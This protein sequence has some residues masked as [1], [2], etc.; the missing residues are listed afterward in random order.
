MKKKIWSKLLSCLVAVA[1]IFAMGAN[2]MAEPVD[3]GSGTEVTEQQEDKETDNKQDDKKPEDQEKNEDPPAQQDD[4]ESGDKTVA[5]ASAE[6]PAAEVAPKSEEPEAAPVPEEGGDTPD[7]SIYYTFTLR[8][9]NWNAADIV[10]STNDPDCVASEPHERNNKFYY[11]DGH[12]SFYLSD[13]CPFTAP[14][15]YEFDGWDIANGL[16]GTIIF[17]IQEDMVAT[18]QWAKINT[19]NSKAGDNIIWKF[20]MNTGTLTLTGTGAMYDYNKYETP[21]YS[22]IDDIERIVVSE[23]ITVIG[24]YAFCDCWYMYSITLP[25]SL[26]TIKNHAFENCASL[27]KIVIPAGVTAIGVSSDPEDEFSDAFRGCRYLY[28]VYLDANPANLTWNE[29][30]NDF[31]LKDPQTVCHVRSEYLSGYNGNSFSEVN[32]KFEGDLC[33]PSMSWSFNADNGELMLSGSGEM[34]DY[35]DAAS[36]PW[37]S[38]KTSI[39]SLS[40]DNSGDITI[41]NDA[42]NGCVNLSGADLDDSGITSIGTSSFEGCTSFKD[43]TFPSSLTSIGSRAFYNSGIQWL[44]I[45]KSINSIGSEAFKNC[46]SLLSVY[47]YSDRISIGKDAFYGCTKCYTI[48]IENNN[49]TAANIE[50]DENNCDDFI[51]G[52]SKAILMVGPSRLQAFIDKFSGKVNVEFMEYQYCPP[53]GYPFG[54]GLT[55]RLDGDGILTI[56]GSGDMPDFDYKQAPWSPFGES[57]IIVSVVIGDQI[58]SIGNHSFCECKTIKSVTI[59]DSVTKIGYGAFMNCFAL[60]N[61]TIPGS[62]KIIDKYAFQ[63]CEFTSITICNGVESIGTDAFAY[64]KLRSVTIPDSVTHLGDCVFYDCGELKSAKL[65]KNLESIEEGTF[66]SCHKLYSVNIPDG[67]TSIGE[68]AFRGCS[69]LSAANIPGSVKTIGDSAFMGCSHMKDLTIAYGVEKIGETAFSTCQSL[70]SITIPDSVTFI[71]RTAFNMCINA[72]TITLPSGI[73]AISDYTFYNCIN[74]KSIVIPNK[75]KTIGEHAFTNCQKMESLII[76]ESVTNIKY[77]AFDNCLVLK[78]ITILSKNIDIKFSA[79]N[80]CP[81]VTDVYCYADPANV[82]WDFSNGYVFNGNRIVPRTEEN[83]KIHVL[84]EFLSAYHEKFDS[85]LPSYIEFIGGAEEINMGSGNSHLYGYTLSLEGNIGVNFYMS[86]DEAITGN[87]STAY[88]LFTV[89]GRTQEVMVKD[90]TATDDGYYIFR[91]NVAAKEMCDQITARLYLADGVESGPS[92]TFAVRDYAS[93]ILNHTASGE[94]GHDPKV[95]ALVK[96]MLNYGACSQIYFN[97]NTGNLANSILDEDERT[98]SAVPEDKISQYYYSGVTQFNAGNRIISFVSA[99]LSAESELV[100]NFYFKGL[101]V[102]TV[103]T[104]N[105]KKLK[106]TLTTDGS[107]TRVSVTGIKVQDIDEDYTLSFTYGGDECSLT[108]SPMNYCYNIITRPVTPTRTQE[109]KDNIAALYWF[110]KAAEN[111][112]SE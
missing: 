111:Y 82:E 77:G 66:T 112:I 96:A 52:D 10:Y 65:S 104:C 75:V 84:T 108:Y 91:C 48:Y 18:A 67:V 83:A 61:V 99:T 106:S 68:E 95:V 50:W 41:G 35:A 17:D 12:W 19:D 79:F 3:G 15:G 4:K 8:E 33:G 36:V 6:E 60:E 24:E 86:L 59:P 100:M 55:W 11:G 2:V 34:F 22:V 44:T 105:G 101:P 56:S 42:F 54:N 13:S 97:H 30:Y 73:T 62:V 76:S 89:N 81:R 69:A 71:D 31:R 23:G 74:L 88:M 92:Y 27:E 72:T 45:T 1:M 43:V 21:W 28:D 20:N 14:D 37:S 70:T 26:T 64:T 46:T 87:N 51:Q 5:G 53:Q 78:T 80:D 103:V 109:Q 9:G 90:L 57:G 110:Y 102:D 32:V 38:V 63:S 40:I 29:E 93:Y 47:L 49:L 7:P 98:V 16:K 94:I 25:D 58:T 39:T 107:Y 85:V